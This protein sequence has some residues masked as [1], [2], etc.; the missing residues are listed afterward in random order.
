M[1]KE[2]AG[3]LSITTP[4]ELVNSE[5]DDF[6]MTIQLRYTSTPALSAAYTQGLP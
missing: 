6:N 5:V 3:T 2:P 4:T 1:M